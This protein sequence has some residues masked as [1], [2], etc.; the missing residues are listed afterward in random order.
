MMS[1]NT[2]RGVMPRSNPAMTLGTISSN[3]MNSAMRGGWRRNVFTI[4]HQGAT[5]VARRSITTRPAPRDSTEFDTGLAFVARRLLL[6][7][8]ALSDY[9]RQ[10]LKDLARSE[11][12]YPFRT[13]KALIAIAPRCPQAH[14]REVLAEFIRERILAQCAPMTCPLV[15]FEEETKA[16]GIAD[17]W[18]WRFARNPTGATR[19][20]VAQ[21]LRHQLAATRLCVDSLAVSAVG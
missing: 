1:P 13:L 8:A 2:S 12:R 14:D 7:G 6:S 17:L 15:A 19:E 18:Q 10:L 5:P 21:A 4:Y 9:E 20:Q 16:Q 11:P 3:R